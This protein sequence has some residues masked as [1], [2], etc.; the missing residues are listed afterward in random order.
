M[1]NVLLWAQRSVISAAVVTLLWGADV[2]YGQGSGLY[3]GTT[4]ALELVD[5]AYAKTTDNT[6]PRNISAHRGKV[7]HNSD[8]DTE[9]GAGFGLLAGYRVWIGQSR[10]L[11]SGELDVALHGGAVRSRQA[12]A[13]E[14]AG[15]N[16]YGESWPDGWA[17]E[18]DWSYGFT[19][20]LGGSPAWL[21]P[22]VG[23]DTSV[24]ALAGVRRLRTRLRLDYTGCPFATALCPPAEFTSGANA[25]TEHLIGWMGRGPGPPTLRIPNGGRIGGGR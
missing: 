15:R 18:K 8:A 2:V 5:T 1:K 4:G 25:W 10:L 9:V 12:G 7:Y 16:Q 13:G 20:K 11:L 23:S 14:S 19:L 21:H 3:V 24:Y 6:D 17:F 22:W